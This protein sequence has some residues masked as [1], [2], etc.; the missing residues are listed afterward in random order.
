MIAGREDIELFN[1]TISE[2]A[3]TNFKM[4]KMV[5]LEKLKKKPLTKKLKSV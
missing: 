1:Q 2:L 4:C 5:L 3:L